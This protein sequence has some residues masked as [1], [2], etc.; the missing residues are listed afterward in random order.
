MDV[1]RQALAEA[2]KAEFED[3]LSGRGGSPRD[4]RWERAAS[5]VADR[6]EGTPV[7]CDHYFKW[8]EDPGDTAVCSKCGAVLTAA[9]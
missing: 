6:L 8:Q 9:T 1:D 3:H 2:L 5:R 4:F 7:E